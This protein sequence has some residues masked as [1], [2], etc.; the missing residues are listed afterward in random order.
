M[1][2]FST[3]QGHDGVHP[4]SR[5]DGLSS[6]F[7]CDIAKKFHSVSGSAPRILTP[8]SSLRAEGEAIQQRIRRRIDC[9][10]FGSQ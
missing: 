7:D 5:S 10:A 9:F 3:R 6:L 2:R 8:S 4:Q 1:H